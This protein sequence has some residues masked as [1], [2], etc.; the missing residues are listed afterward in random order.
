MS[1]SRPRLS[2]SQR[3]WFPA[4]SLISFASQRRVSASSQR[5]SA[6][7]RDCYRCVSFASQRVSDTP[8]YYVGEGAARSRRPFTS[9]KEKIA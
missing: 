9:A 6:F 3:P 4:K 1:R 5:V 2:A 7:V 8:P